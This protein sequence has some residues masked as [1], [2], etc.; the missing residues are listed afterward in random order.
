MLLPSVL[1]GLA[2]NLLIL[3]R[4]IDFIVLHL[5]G[6]YLVA[7]VVLAY[8]L[9]PLAALIC[10]ACY[11]ATLTTSI[12]T[13]RLLLHRLCRFPGPLGAKVSKLWLMFQTW[14]KPQMHLLTDKL[15]KEHGDFV[16][17]GMIPQPPTSSRC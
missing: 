15:H 14:K 4:E 3:H 2:T 6:L 17:V 1:A 10:A 13:H 7:I 16:R 12:L 5:L 8:V 11:N 9:T